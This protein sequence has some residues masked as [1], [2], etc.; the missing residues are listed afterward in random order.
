MLG[1]MIQT[2]A[3]GAFLDSEGSHFIGRRSYL[4][5]FI[6]SFSEKQRLLVGAIADT[7]IPNTDTPGAVEAGV[8]K[9]IELMFADWMRDDERQ[10]FSAN[11]IDVDNSAQQM[12]EEDFVNCSVEEQTEILQAIEQI[13]GDHSWYELGNLENAFSAGAPFIAQ[14]K[15]LTVVGYFMSEVGATQ[16]LRFN[17]VPGRFDGDT[18]LDL[19]DNA[20]TPV[21]MM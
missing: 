12:F 13:D 8:P 11:L 4:D 10:A 2:R 17:H 3:L 7:I 15:E 9:F 6:E 14:I 19:H 18:P 5:N 21:P 20:W 1:G 16:V